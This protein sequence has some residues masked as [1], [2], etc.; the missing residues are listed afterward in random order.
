MHQI[1]EQR[2]AGP[3]QRNALTLPLP[4]VPP[5]A[6][7]ICAIRQARAARAERAARGRGAGEGLVHHDLTLVQL[8]GLGLDLLQQPG[9]FAACSRAMSS[10]YL[11]KT[12]AGH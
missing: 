6:H 4:R 8:R 5:L 7:L 1:G 11:S 12:P 9:G 10:W 3:L 2:S